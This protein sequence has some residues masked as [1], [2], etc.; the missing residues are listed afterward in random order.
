MKIT[1]TKVVSLITLCI[2]VIFLIKW[3]IS[4]FLFIAEYIALS[5]SEIIAKRIGTLINIAAITPGDAFMFETFPFPAGSYF[6]Y[7]NESYLLVH[8]TFRGVFAPTTFVLK[9]F[10]V[11]PFN[12]TLNY[13]EQRFLIFLIRSQNGDIIV[14]PVVEYD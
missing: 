7:S 6:I 11:T 5:P 2:F 9:T 8:S 12:F 4:N 3:L 10:N 14:E 13:D 1:V